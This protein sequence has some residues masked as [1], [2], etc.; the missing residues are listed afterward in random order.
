M[1]KFINTLTQDIYG[2]VGHKN[3]WITQPIAERFGSD[4]GRKLLESA[5]PRNK[6][7]RLR[8]S[9]MGIK[10][11]HQLWH[12][13]HTPELAIPPHPWTMIKF[14]YGHI[15]EL[16]AIALAK[17]AG[18]E[19]VGEQ[20]EIYLDGIL[21]HRDC[22]I[23]GCIVDVKSVNSRS[24][25]KFK[26]GTLGDNDLFGYLDQLD[27]YVIGSR[28]DPAVRNKTTGYLLAIDQELGHLKLYEHIAREESIRE[29]IRTFRDVVA[30]DQ[31]PGCTCETTPDGKSGNIKLGIVAK[32]NA[33]RYCCFPQLRC[34][35]YGSGPVFLTKVVRKPDVPEVDRF[36]KF[37]Y[38]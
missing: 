8:L 37:V 17:A 22:V 5:G 20:D 29:R 34:F 31:P 27:G 38:N 26:N 18:H 7:P 6:V 33:F 28:N 3:G 2:I 32:Y 30:L 36:G 13:I 4:V 24:F 16:Y 15:L 9:E 12:S 19:V 23:D 25:E 35:L 11:P 10:C 14:Q 21:G 1:V